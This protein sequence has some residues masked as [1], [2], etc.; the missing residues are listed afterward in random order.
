MQK[1]EL[2]DESQDVY[3]YQGFEI[4][5]RIKI[6]NR[7]ATQFLEGFKWIISNDGSKELVTV[8][9]AGDTFNEAKHSICEKINYFLKQGEVPS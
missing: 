8:N 1:W 2:I 6:I 7:R 9:A 5:H 4:Q 3:S